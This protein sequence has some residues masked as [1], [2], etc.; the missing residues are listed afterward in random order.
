MKKKV[1]E[2]LNTQKMNEFKAFEIN[3]K[4]LAYGNSFR[5]GIDA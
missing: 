5:Q 3:K 2:F 1:L 4:K